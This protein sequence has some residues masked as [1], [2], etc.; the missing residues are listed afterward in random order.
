[1]PVKPPSWSFRR[2]NAPSHHGSIRGNPA[3]GFAGLTLSCT[4]HKTGLNPNF[5]PHG[6]NSS[7]PSLER[8]TGLAHAEGRV[9][10]E[11]D[12]K[13]HDTGVEEVVP[14]PE[15]LPIHDV[16]L[17]DAL[18]QRRLCG[19]D[20]LHGLD[21]G[22]HCVRR[23]DAGRWQDLE[24]FFRGGA[25]P[26]GVVE[27]DGRRWQACEQGGDVARHRTAGMSD[28]MF[29]DCDDGGEACQ[30]WWVVDGARG[31]GHAAYRDDK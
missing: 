28:A 26:A 4:F 6:E 7:S 30:F 25:G 8:T 20:G 29:I 11:E 10:K 27:N 16:D 9:W 15:L 21:H 14:I 12:S 23:V 17:D 22:R 24:E 18:P 3:S 2:N 1:M 5:L 13:V 31:S 19:D